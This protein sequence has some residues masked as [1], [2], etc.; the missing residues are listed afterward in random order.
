M[1]Q[2]HAINSIQLNTFKAHFLTF[3]NQY[4]L[5]GGIASNLLLDDA[6][7]TTNRT[8]KD[9]DIVLCIE[10][11]T[12]DFVLHFWKSIRD[13]DYECSVKS[14]NKRCLYRFEKPQ[15]PKYP[16]MLELL[17]DKSILLEGIDQTTHPIIVDDE[18]VSLSA[19]MLNEEYYQFLMK[20]KIEINGIMV[21]NEIAIIP[22]KFVHI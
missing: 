19:I 20:N 11:I 18:I 5:I 15:N 3:K 16:Y 17:S 13:G 1:A 21:V 8:T 6:G 7:I 14:S 9:L 2:S 12:N 10:A 22:L 4:V